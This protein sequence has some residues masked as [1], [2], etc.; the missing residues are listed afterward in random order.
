M[1][2]T[3]NSCAN[4]GVERSLNTNEIDEVSES[5][6]LN[7]HVEGFFNDSHFEET[8]G[9]D[10]LSSIEKQDSFLVED[11]STIG[12]GC[13]NQLQG[14]QLTEQES[15]LCE[16]TRKLDDLYYE[17]L[18]KIHENMEY[19]TEIKKDEDWEFSEHSDN[20]EEM[21]EA[22]KPEVSVNHESQQDKPVYEGCPITVIIIKFPY[23]ARSDWLKQ[24]PLSE[25]R[26]QV[27]DGK[28]ASSNFL[29]RNFDKFDPN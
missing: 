16:H 11:V 18:S 15:W 20:P 26:E 1:S 7:S 10:E 4:K 29:L 8:I 3:R 2:V 27:D 12:E 6:S 28:L 25:N 23:N 22:D 24:R 14:E 13:A 9:Y 5:E 19:S 21:L 17:E